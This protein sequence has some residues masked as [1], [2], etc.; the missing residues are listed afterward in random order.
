MVARLNV[1]TG[2]VGANGTVNAA[3]VAQVKSLSGQTTGTANFRA[4]LNEDGVINAADVAL[5][6][7][8]SG[9]AIP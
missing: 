1:L 5:V 3:D 8:K 2:D 6:K 9:T 7:S 4:D